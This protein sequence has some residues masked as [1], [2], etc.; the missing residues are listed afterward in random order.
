MDDALLTTAEVAAIVER[1][2]A[3]VTRWVQAGRLVATHKLANGHLLFDPDDV[4]ALAAD[5]D[6]DT[7]L[8]TERKARQ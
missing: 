2:R 7:R 3:T 8:A 5:L 4:R 6:T 1:D